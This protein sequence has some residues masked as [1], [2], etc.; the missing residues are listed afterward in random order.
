MEWVLAVLGVLA[1]TGALGVVLVMR[2]LRALRQRA[3]AVA[4]RAG[5]RARA[6]LGVG[7]S[8]ELARCR[9]ELAEAVTGLR[10][11]LAVAHD[12]DTPVGDVPALLRRLE[13]AA[14]AVDGE[15]RV[16]EA[17]RDPRRIA[18]VL[19]GPRTRAA[20]IIESADDLARALAEAGAGASADVATLRAE[21]TLE[22][23]ALREA[24]HEVGELSRPARSPRPA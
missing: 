10:R 14:E 4:D 23:Q 12:H 16:I 15:L 21:C 7:A 5:L 11:A 2:V 17:L 1:L 24:G 9:R 13:A 8:A 18:A 3:R 6:T 19:P 20:A 22:A